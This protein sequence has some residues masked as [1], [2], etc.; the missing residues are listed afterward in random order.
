MANPS[1]WRRGGYEEWFRFFF[2]SMLPEDHSTKQREDAVGWACDVPIETMIAA[3]SAPIDLKE[4]DVIS[5]ID[6]LDLDMLVIHETED[7]CQLIER[8][9]A[10]AARA[11]ADLLEMEGT[12]HIP[13]AREPVAVNQAILR[14]M[15]RL[16]ASA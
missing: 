1:F 5:M 12:G 9:R 15:D 6:R 8:G 10:L 2:A 14:F 7:G 16:G 11:G 3:E 4:D 13:G